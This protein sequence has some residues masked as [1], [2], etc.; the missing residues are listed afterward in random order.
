MRNNNLIKCAVW[1]AAAIICLLVLISAGHGVYI[2]AGAM[3]LI[4]MAVS[5]F[6]WVRFAMP[7]TKNAFNFR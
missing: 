4:C 7:L 5:M 3:S 6:Y 2:A 1:M